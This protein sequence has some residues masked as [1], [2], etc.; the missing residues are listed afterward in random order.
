MA[1][2]GVQRN[3][4]KKFS[5]VVEIAGVAH[6]GFVTCSPIQVQVAKIEH[7]E[8]GALIPNKQ[9]GLITVPDVTLT[10]GATDDLDLWNWV[11]EAIA[12]GGILVDDGQKRTL[13]IVQTNR[14]GAEL[15]RWTL[16]NAWPVDY[17]AGEWDNNADENT[18]ETLILTYDFPD[19]GG[20]G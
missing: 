12:L 17:I 3:Y 11:K 7:R 20:D 18:M 14:A 5:F 19:L 13:D 8:G 10:R 16:A 2:F 1:I 4:Y 9:P 15:R 6:A